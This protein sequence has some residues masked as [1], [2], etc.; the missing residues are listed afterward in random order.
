MHCQSIFLVC[1]Q[2]MPIRVSVEYAAVILQSCVCIALP[3]FKF[4]SGVRLALFLYISF[5]SI[6]KSSEKHGLRILRFSELQDRIVP[7]SSVPRPRKV[8]HVEEG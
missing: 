2:N 7:L 8:T 4:Q 1:Q 6:E 5:S 3:L